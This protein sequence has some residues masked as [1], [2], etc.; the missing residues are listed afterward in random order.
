MMLRNL[1]FFNFFVLISSGKLDS[2]FKKVDPGRHVATNHKLVIRSADG[3]EVLMGTQSENQFRAEARDA[4]N[5]VKGVYSWLDALGNEHTVAYNSGINGYQTMPLEKSG[6][7]LPPYPYGLYGAKPKDVQGRT[8]TKAD[9]KSGTVVCD[10]LVVIGLEDDILEE[11]ATSTTTTEQTP[12][13]PEEGGVEVIEVEGAE[14]LKITIGTPVAASRPWASAVAG[15]NSTAEAR[16]SAQAFVGPGGV[17]ISFPTAEATVGANGVAVSRPL[18]ASVAGHGG[19]AVAGGHSV[20]SAG[21]Q[22]SVKVNLPQFKSIGE[23]T[24]MTGGAVPKVVILPIVANYHLYGGYPMHYPLR[25]LAPQPL[26]PQPIRSQPLPIRSQP[27]QPQPLWPQ[28]PF[29]SGKKRKRSP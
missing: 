19:I 21:L 14:G 23:N 29:F 20:A 4:N 1:L 18:S 12:E 5:E 3:K 7:A 15:D 26:Q 10:D 28:H 2:K 22:Q 9:C 11:Q 16:P 6:I 25:S 8:K 13:V 17:A 24:Q 27:L